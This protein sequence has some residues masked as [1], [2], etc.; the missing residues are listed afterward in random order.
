MIKPGDIYRHTRNNKLYMVTQTFPLKVNGTWGHGV[1]Y[2]RETEYY[3]RPLEDFEANF[4][5]ED[6]ANPPLKPLADAKTTT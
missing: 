6:P 3:A 2:M 1:L 5:I 4:E